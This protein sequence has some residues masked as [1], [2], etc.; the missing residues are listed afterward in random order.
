MKTLPIDKE[1]EIR[2]LFNLGKNGKQIAEIL[3]ISTHA[4]YNVKDMLDLIS[5]I[6]EEQKTEI[7]EL[8]LSKFPVESIIVRTKLPR[9]T[10][11]AVRRY[12]FLHK[13]ENDKKLGVCPT[14]GKITIPSKESNDFSVNDNIS[15]IK[16]IFFELISLSNLHII[17]N[18]LFYDII[19]KIR[20]VMSSGEEK[21]N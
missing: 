2:E 21:T 13:W 11:I 5:S 16:K 6:T 10:I 8:I 7:K 9:K 19:A 18:P 1:K 15:L 3:G 4:V 20:K 14:C 12:Y 17:H